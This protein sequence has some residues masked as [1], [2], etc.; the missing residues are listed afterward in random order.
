[1]RIDFR[2]GRGSPILGFFP[3]KYQRL[4]TKV[5]TDSMFKVPHVPL[6]SSDTGHGWYPDG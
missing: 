2:F 3:I 1:M 4:S 5:Y 6:K